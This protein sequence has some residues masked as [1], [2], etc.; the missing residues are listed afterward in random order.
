[1][2]H[3]GV[4]VALFVLVLLHFGAGEEVKVALLVQRQV[5]LAGDRVRGQVELVQAF[6]PSNEHAG[7]AVHCVANVRR[8][9]VIRK[10]S[11]HSRVVSSSV[12]LEKH[13]LVRY[14]ACE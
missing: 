13:F 4:R 10:K 8:A 6:H 11:V 9:D 3:G 12:R 5:G 7:A 1:M 2:R 14:I